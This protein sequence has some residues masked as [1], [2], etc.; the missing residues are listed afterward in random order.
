MAEGERQS[1]PGRAL[2]PGEA[3]VGG[4]GA[5]PAVGAGKGRVGRWRI[6]RGWS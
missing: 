3:G 1:P 4:A 6:A 2:R 5:V